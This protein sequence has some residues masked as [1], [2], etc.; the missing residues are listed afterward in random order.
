MTYLQALVLGA[1]QGITELFPISSLGHSVILPSLFGW[2]IDQNNPTFLT[3]LVAT[4][5]ATALVLFF[6]FTHDWILILK[7]MWKSFTARAISAGGAYGKLGWLLLVA[8]I[9]AGIFGVL[10]QD[11][12]RALFASPRIVAGVLILNGLMLFGA[13]MLRRQKNG[14]F[15]NNAG[16]ESD[17]RA[18]RL[19]WWQAVKVGCMQILALIP[20]FSRTGATI[21]GGLLEGLSYEDAARFSFLLATPIIGAAALLELPSLFTAPGENMVLGTTLAGAAAAALFAYLSTRFLLS[22]FETKKLWPFAVYCVVI[23]IIV[24][25]ILL[26]V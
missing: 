5:F 26:R 18:A 16:E 2:N 14:I 3:F 19:S 25:V 21:T 4:H 1:I 22:Y 10:F 15:E 17:E 24:S 20:G 13:D 6:Y 23:G 7:G 11:S 12:L 8:T 9:P